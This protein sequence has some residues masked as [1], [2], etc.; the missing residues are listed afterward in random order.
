MRTETDTGTKTAT[1]T[2]TAKE[3]IKMRPVMTRT[4]RKTRVRQEYRQ[5]QMQ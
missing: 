5:P 3:E 4:T 1:V 2:K